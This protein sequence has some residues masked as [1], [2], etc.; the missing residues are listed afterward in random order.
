MS[1][2]IAYQYTKFCS[3]FN[4]LTSNVCAKS[5]VFNLE[6]FHSQKELKTQSVET[7]TKKVSGSAVCD[8][9]SVVAYVRVYVT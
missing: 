9:Y 1:F 5:I 4:S 8:I 2:W 6:H 3:S 7:F